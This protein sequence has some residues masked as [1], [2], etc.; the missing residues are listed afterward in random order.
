MA[1]LKPIGVNLVTGQLNYTSANDILRPNEG[2]L[3]ISG[4][5]TQLDGTV[6]TL[7]GGDANATIDSAGG[8]VFITAPAGNANANGGRLEMTCGNS[9][10]TSGD[11]GYFQFTAG[12]AVTNGS[13]GGFTFTAGDSAGVN[14]GGGF[15]FTPGTGYDVGGFSMQVQ[16]YSTTP[17]GGV[18]NIKGGSNGTSGN[19]AVNIE[20]HGQTTV[21]GKGSSS[22]L[23]QTGTGDDV[24]GGV[25]IDTGGTGLTGGAI[26]IG[27]NNAASIVM[28]AQGNPDQT[29]DIY[30]FFTP[31]VTANQTN[32]GTGAGDTGGL[33]LLRPGYQ[34]FGEFTGTVLNFGPTYYD[35]NNG[36]LFRV[37]ASIYIDGDGV[38][39]TLN[40][41]DATHPKDQI[42]TTIGSVDAAYDLAGV[43]LSQFP[44]V[45][46]TVIIRGILAGAFVVSSVTD[47]GSGS[48][49]A[50]ALLPSGGTV[51]YATGALTG[52]TAT[53]EA[54]SQV[55]AYYVFAN[56]NGEALTPRGGHGQGTGDGGALNLRGGM[57]GATGDGAAVTIAGGA[58]GSTSG[59]SG[60][61][62]I[63][64]GSVTS[65]TIAD[66]SIGATAA[67]NIILGDSALTSQVILFNNRFQ[68]FQGT[69]V[70][71][72]NDI[73]LGRGNYFDITGATTINRI[74]SA[75]WR[76]GSTI[77]LRFD[78]N[79]QI[80]DGVAA[81]GGF[82]S[83]LLNGTAN[84]ATTAG[85]TLTLLFDGTSFVE[86]A[87]MTR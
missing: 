6:L 85:S 13:G 67:T 38:V 50:S 69:D 54:F 29:V 78:S 9:G 74:A 71:S 41:G 43:G 80:T 59:N 27:A 77:R 84:F 58:G 75:G 79:P 66:I 28:G 49:P 56:Q 1:I 35:P 23:I 19:Y 8:S 44:V 83:I 47:N 30:N 86:T 51:N 37:G 61:I 68:G 3:T 36:Q 33:I 64:A 53:L 2:D 15:N 7:K 18:V 42:L 65:G 55:T 87:R 46:G 82:A 31:T 40:G 34:T 39:N 81:G 26:N 10:A 62:T 76:A 63:N 4:G 17:S 16:N 11:G 70:T 48:F 14:G 45:T 25:D 5:N 57:G 12:N 24:A 73:T 72:A 32:I 21:V 22:I 52:T 20:T 60:G